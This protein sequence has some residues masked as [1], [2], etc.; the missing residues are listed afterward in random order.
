MRVEDQYSFADDAEVGSLYNDAP[1]RLPAFRKFM[2]LATSRPN[3]L[4]PW[5]TLQ[6]ATECWKWGMSNGGHYNR[7][8]VVEKRARR[9]KRYCGDAVQDGGRGWADL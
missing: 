6:K 8:G 1:S 5:W 9:T 3:L 2:R 4:P 7:D